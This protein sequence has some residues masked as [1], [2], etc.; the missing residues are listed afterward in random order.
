MR[1]PDS[2]FDRDEILKLLAELDEE[3]ELALQGDERGAAVI[4]DRRREKEELFEAMCLASLPFYAKYVLHIEVAEHHVSWSELI[5]KT[6]EKA[7]QPDRIRATL[8]LLAP[9]GHGKSA[10]FSYALPIWLAHKIFPGDYGALVGEGDIALL[11]LKHIKQ[12]TPNRDLPGILNTPELRHLKKSGSKGW[13]AELIEL[14]NGSEIFAKGAKAAWRGKHPRWLVPDDLLSQECLFSPTERKKVHEN[15]ISQLMPMV[16]GPIFIVGTPMHSTDIYAYCKKQKGFLYKRFAALSTDPETG[17]EKALWPERFSIPQLKVMRDEELGPIVFSRE[18]LCKAISSIS[19]LFPPELFVP[20]VMDETWCIRP[21]A[22]WWLKHCSAGRFISLDIGISA[23]LS[24]DFTV[25]MVWG[26]DEFG[27]RYLLDLVRERGLGFQGIIKRFIALGSMYGVDAG[28]IESNQA[29]AFVG[30]EAIA[31]APF[32]IDMHQ[33]GSEK[34]LWERGVPMLRLLFEN[35]K[36]RLPR[37]D[38]ESISLT[39]T[40]IRELQA[41]TVDDGKVVSTAKYKDTVMAAWFTELLLRRMSFGGAFFEEQEGDD[42]AVAS[43]WGE[44]NLDGP[45]AREVSE[46]FGRRNEGEVPT[47]EDVINPEMWVA[48]RWDLKQLLH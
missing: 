41:H 15:L 25:I 28:I 7:E 29:Q 27:N 2:H 13:T 10:W 37:G 21:P 39:D 19:S 18:Y 24:A 5:L 47:G 46:S 20:P 26:L 9:R 1:V 23:N 16:R 14:T 44:D 33:T 30:N 35:K 17:E 45:A 22:D 31:Q 34:H 42:A 32:P 3:E 38:A 48:S 40:F 12:G 43:Y 6:L 4:L 36:Y 11:H 8:C